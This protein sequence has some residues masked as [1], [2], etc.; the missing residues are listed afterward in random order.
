M[1]LTMMTLRR[2]L[3]AVLLLSSATSLVAAPPD[4]PHDLHGDALPTGAVLR[5]GP[6][7]LRHAGGVHAILY[8][9]DGKTLASA[10]WDGTVCLWDTDS[11]REIRRMTELR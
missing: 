3:S 8:A 9:H 10:A 5:L 11:G 7:R 2:V 6:T 1:V 4:S